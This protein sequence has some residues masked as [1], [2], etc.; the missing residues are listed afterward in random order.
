M[1]YSILYLAIYEKKRKISA[2]NREIL[3]KRK[4]TVLAA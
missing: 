1:F 3:I 2:D 4:E